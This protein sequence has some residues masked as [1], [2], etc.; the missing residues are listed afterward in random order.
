MALCKWKK[1]WLPVRMNFDQ[2]ESRKISLRD[3]HGRFQGRGNFDHRNR[4]K[5]SH[6]PVQNTLL[7]VQITLGNRKYNCRYDPGIWCVYNSTDMLYG[8]DF[9]GWQLSNQRTKPAII[10]WLRCFFPG[11]DR[12]IP[13]FD[14]FIPGFDRFIPASI[15][16]TGSLPPYNQKHM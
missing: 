15:P 4:W 14:R 9:E 8:S 3:C 5:I 16:V 11:F 12:F 2:S 6:F 7:P 1:E 13:G 10:T